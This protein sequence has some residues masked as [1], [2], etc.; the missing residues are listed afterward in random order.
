MHSTYTLLQIENSLISLQNQIIAA[1]IQKIP[2]TTK[3]IRG[4]FTAQLFF[5]Y[6][7]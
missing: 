7:A 5:T 3:M 6:S 4:F 2:E 1:K